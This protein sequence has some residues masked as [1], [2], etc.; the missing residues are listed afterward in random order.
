MA[1]PMRSTEFRSVVEPILNEIF[2][3]VYEQRADEWR[4]VFKDRKGIQRAYHEEPVLYGFPAAPEIPDGNP[5]TYQS[6]GVLFVYRYVYR[7]YGL[8]FALTK[9]LVEDGDHIQI[10]IVRHLLQHR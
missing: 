4:Q 8:A 1:T 2:D 10:G 7:V 6:G 5:V 9:I 3:G